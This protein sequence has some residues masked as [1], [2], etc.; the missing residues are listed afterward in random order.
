MRICLL[1]GLITD[2]TF[3]LVY[4]FLSD[5]NGA[6]WFLLIGPVFEGFLGGTAGF[7][8]SPRASTEAHYRPPR[9]HGEYPR[10]C[11]GLHR[12]TASVQGLLHLS[13]T[14]VYRHGH[15]TCLRWSLDPAVGRYPDS[16]LLRLCEPFAVR[17]RRLARHP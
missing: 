6:Y 11:R 3:L 16:L 2:I 13:W 15:R 10:L 8:G 12:S 5:H 4:L 1:G 17:I 9:R 7:I 14:G